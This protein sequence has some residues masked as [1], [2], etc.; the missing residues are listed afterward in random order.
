MDQA[1]LTLWAAILGPLVSAVTV[2]AAIGRAG[3]WTQARESEAAA[4]RQQLTSCRQQ[5]DVSLKE[6]R[7][8]GSDYAHKGIHDVRGDLQTSVM[9]LG[10]EF[11]RKDL[12][13]AGFAAL[14]ELMQTNSNSVCQ[15]LDKIEERLEAA[16]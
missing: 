1:T 3:R 11:A 4:I 10:V 12:V 15:R 14:R 13:E 9:R 7:D 16:K 8:H 6:L 2:L 5:C